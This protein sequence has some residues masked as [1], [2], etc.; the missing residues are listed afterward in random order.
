VK[1][2]EQLVG[3]M[4]LQA[5]F[6]DPR[7]PPLAPEELK[8]VE[9]EISL[10]TEPHRVA[11]DVEILPGRDG[12]I[13]EKSGKAAVFLPQVATEQGWGRHELLDNLCF[14]AGLGDDCWAK[15]AALSVFR[16]RVFRER[17]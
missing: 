2:L 4:A 3:A 15:G 9:I 6:A 17:G 14:K 10:L 7:F 11:S 16:A 13:L 12:V 5:A 8:A 1:P